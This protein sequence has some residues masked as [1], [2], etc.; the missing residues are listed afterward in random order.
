VG[1]L[2]VAGV[3]ASKAGWVAAVV[4]SV[5]FARALAGPGFGELL[6]GMP[7]VVAVGVDI[8]IRTAGEPST[9]GGS[10]RP[11]VRWSQE[12]E[13][14]PDPTPCPARSRYLCGGAAGRKGAVR[15]R[16]IGSGLRPRTKDPRVDAVR[17]D[18]VIGVHP[19]VSFRAMAGSE[20]G[21]PKNT[22]AGHERRRAL[23]AAEGIT[24][25]GEVGAAG[26]AASD[27]VLDAAAAAW[28]ARRK[29]HGEARTLPESGSAGRHPAIWY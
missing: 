15:D 13:R 17:D 27:D 7:D 26:R 24:V 2:L 10:G 3:D 14:I 20:L 11:E 19:E 16:N 9:V 29:A 21:D 12:I 28:S 6:E 23:L 4:D 5:G 25:P 18:R 8:P 1:G 22:W